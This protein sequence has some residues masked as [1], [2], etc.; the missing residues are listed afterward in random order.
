VR[1]GIIALL[2]ETNTFIDRQTELVDFESDL[3]AV[4][5]QVRELLEDA[6]HEVGGF[7]E[8]LRA[9]GVVAAPIFAARALPFGVI[10]QDVYE[11]LVAMMLCELERSG[12]VDGLLV[13]PHGA[14]VAEGAPDADGEWLRRV[15]ENLGPGVPIIGTIDPHANVSDLMVDST[16]ALLAYRTNPHLDQ[17]AIGA[18]AA[19][20]L[21][22]TL[23]GEVRPTQVLT[24]VPTVIGIERQSTEEAPLRDVLLAAD[25]MLRRPEVLSD[26]VVIGFPYA[27][28]EEMGAA[29]IV[30]TDDDESTARRLSR[31][32]AEE[33]RI[34]QHELAGAG[35]TIDEALDRVSRAQGPVCLLDM[36]DNVGGGSPG[37]S[38]FL[39][40]AII[41]RGIAPAFV[42]L[43]D[44]VAARTAGEAGVGARLDLGVGGKT[45]DRHGEPLL[46]S[47]E[48]IGLH[49]GRFRETQPRHGGIVDF[50]QGP[51]AVV[52]CARGLT[53]ML[54][55]RR[56]APFSLRQISD[57]GLDPR[58][59]RVLV[60][61]GVHSPVAAYAPVCRHLIRVDTP[62]VT[63]AD[64][65]RLDYVHRRK[66]M[67]PF[68]DPAR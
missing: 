13:A 60:A 22:R 19:R 5:E 56:M 31:E 28:V 64:V 66:P 53:V 58:D 10:R 50:D 24:T 46:D 44:A 4:G 59:F 2:Q 38:T 1:V 67:F 30:V 27:D 21:T 33:I 15:R 45:D 47:F 20:L 14:T 35:V 41:E 40:R 43:A 25:R 32:L 54:T 57:H 6:H 42:C 63:T 16:D 62:G 37:D 29:A 68:E 65:R 55:T 49:D 18:R 9:E 51:T 36:G 8:A 52:R 23:R 12:P 3:L 61:K 26:S 7:F 39:A 48:V 17:R 34:R 11:R